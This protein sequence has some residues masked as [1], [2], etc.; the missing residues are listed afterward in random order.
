MARQLLRFAKDGINDYSSHGK[1][2]AVNPDETGTKAAAHY[3]LHVVPAGE[4]RH[5]QA[6]P[7]QGKL[8]RQQESTGR[9]LRPHFR[10]AH[11]RSRRILRTLSPESLS[12]DGRN[13]LRQALAGMLWSKQ[14]Y[15]YVQ[16]DW[17]NGDPISTRAA[18]AT[19]ARPQQRLA[20]S[21]QR[22]RNFHARQMGISVVCRVGPGFPLRSA[23]A[24]RCR[25]RQGAAR[26]CS[27]ANG[28]CIPTASCPPMNGPWA[29]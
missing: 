20:A 10:P 14:F 8:A 23:R 2:G 29:M 1:Q 6:S 27:C 25:F 15:H 17:A 24:G 18:R 28:T 22:R 16:R 3:A 21:L 4:Q 26:C 9:R 12:E 13:V 7:D 19:Q 11:S 5:H